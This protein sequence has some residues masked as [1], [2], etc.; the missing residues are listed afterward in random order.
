MVGFEVIDGYLLGAPVS[1]PDVLSALLA[2]RSPDP[3]AAP[4]YRAL[5]AVGAQAADEALLAL[6]LVLAGKAP[7]DDAVRRLRALAGIARACANGDRGGV[8]AL[9]KKDPRS[10]GPLGAMQPG[11]LTQ[12]GEAARAAYFSELGR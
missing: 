10:L 12:L 5:E 8:A 4:F 3:A 11:D 2:E 7:S 6:R 9:V 1:K